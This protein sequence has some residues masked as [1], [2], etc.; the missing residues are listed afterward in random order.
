MCAARCGAQS[1]TNRAGGVWAV[2]IPGLFTGD[3]GSI[4]APGPRAAAQQSTPERSRRTPVLPAELTTAI[5]AVTELFTEF[6]T[7][8]SGIVFPTVLTPVSVLAAF[9]LIFPILIVVL[10]FLYRLVRGSSS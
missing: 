7:L 8:I 2:H 3:A 5:E 4:P 6:F 1:S 9:G 10:G